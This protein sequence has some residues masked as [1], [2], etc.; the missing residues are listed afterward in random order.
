LIFVIHFHSV[1]STAMPLF[2]FYIVVDGFSELLLQLCRF[3]LAACFSGL[4]ALLLLNLPTM[5]A[6]LYQCIATFAVNECEHFGD[7]KRAYEE[8]CRDVAPKIEPMDRS[9]LG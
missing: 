3:S 8:K 4:L 7:G 6:D 9:S 5:G 2:D 1:G